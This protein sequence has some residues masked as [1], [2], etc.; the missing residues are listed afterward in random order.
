MRLRYAGVARDASAAPSR[1]F[2]VPDDTL[3]RAQADARGIDG[4]AD[5]LGG[6]VPHAFVATKV[7]T[8]PLVAADA[9]APAGWA[10]ALGAA[11]APATLPGYAAFSAVDA[12]RAFE[13]L[14]VLADVRLKLPTGIGGRGQWRLRAP[15][16]LR[17]RLDALPQG[18]LAQHGVVLE[19][20]LRDAETFSV[21]ELRCAG[22]DIAYHGTQTTTRDAEGHEVYAGS[23]LWVVRGTLDDLLATPLPERTRHAVLDA[24]VY[25]R[26]TRQAYAGLVASRRNYDLVRGL[27]ALGNPLSGVLEQS[28]R[29]GGA[30]PAE[31]AA[32]ALFQA[33]P[34][35]Q[36]VHAATRECHDAQVPPP[37][38]E[39][40]YTAAAGAA[41][42][43]CKYRTRTAIDVPWKPSSQASKSPSTTTR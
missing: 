3:T 1:R 7:I 6:V 26:F 14:R 30:T 2:H 39:I 33:D 41:G 12:E 11:L 16:Q 8:H 38:A 42:P 27:D 31:L 13:R 32:I 10:H 23:D 37:A 35:V 21:G 18:Y 36:L 15:A 25:D 34:E 19:Q 22:I 17:E 40:Y 4:A 43:R 24:R 28:W 29:V 5:L 20:D 9:C